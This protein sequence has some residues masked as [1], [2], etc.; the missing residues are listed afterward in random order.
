MIVWMFIMHMHL[1]EPR[2]GVLVRL[3]SSIF[4][5][6]TPALPTDIPP[7]EYAGGT[8]SRRLLEYAPQSSPATT[9]YASNRTVKIFFVFR[10]NV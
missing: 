1:E 4:N 6:V 5:P 7:K 9:V 10:R 8:P 2:T 3:W